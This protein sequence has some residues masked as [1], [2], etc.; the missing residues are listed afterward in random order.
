[1]LAKVVI[2]MLYCHQTILLNHNSVGT[3]FV[4]AGSFRRIQ[5]SYAP[6]SPGHGL[7]AEECIARKVLRVTLAWNQAQDG[8]V[9]AVD[10]RGFHSSICDVWF[11]FCCRDGWF[12]LIFTVNE[13]K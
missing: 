13:C 6:P 1:M 12:M 5:I 4:F 9:E 10:P 7:G 3:L 8:S 2:V 11:L